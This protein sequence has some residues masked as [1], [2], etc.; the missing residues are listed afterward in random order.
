VQGMVKARKQEAESRLKIEPFLP[1][2]RAQLEGIG[3]ITQVVDEAFL[4]LQEKPE[5]Y[6][7]C[8]ADSLFDAAFA[9]CND[10]IPNNVTDDPDAAA[11]NE[12]IDK[13]RIIALDTADQERDKRRAD[14][15]NR[16]RV[17]DVLAEEELSVSTFLLP[18][19]DICFFQTWCAAHPSETESNPKSARL[20][21][22]TGPSGSSLNSS[23]NTDSS[24][25]LVCFRSNLADLLELESDAHRWYGESSK[26][27]F[28]ELGKKVLSLFPDPPADASHGNKRP[29]SSVVGHDSTDE[30]RKLLILVKDAL[31]R[32]VDAVQMVSC[33]PQ[34]RA[35]VLLSEPPHIEQDF[36]RMPERGGQIPSIIV[37]AERR[38]RG[39][40]VVVAHAAPGEAISIPD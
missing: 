23:A 3:F 32:E 40:S 31:R 17:C 22:S 24:S 38:H 36:F 29:A 16:W 26:Y 8:D 9:I 20:T 15:K 30:S 39:S 33:F 7:E 6:D 34:F 10:I 12:Q 4:K 13:A 2:I 11:E 14:R 18:L 21:T 25:E 37:E 27:L 28:G 5:E 19:R 1:G 35:K